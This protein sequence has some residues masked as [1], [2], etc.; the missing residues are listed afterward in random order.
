MLFTQD[1]IP[2]KCR[3]DPAASFISS[4]SL[5]G[6]FSVHLFE[7][8]HVAGDLPRLGKVLA[9]LVL[10]HI[11][12][13]PQSTRGLLR[14]AFP[15][16]LLRLAVALVALEAALA[17]I[18]APLGGQLVVV[19]GQGGGDG[20]AGGRGAPGTQGLGTAVVVILLGSPLTTGE[21]HDGS[22]SVRIRQLV[23]PF[24]TAAVI[25]VGVIG[26]GRTPGKRPRL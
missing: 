13:V 21:P 19:V 2:A 17:A 24:F 26:K 22:L 4:S 8:Q 25:P 20:V 12:A 23:R 16:I 1:L 14:A 15:V 3:I 7:G 18:L 5:L 9:L 11:D 10:G 6:G